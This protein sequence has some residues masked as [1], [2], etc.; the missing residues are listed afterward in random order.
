MCKIIVPLDQV[1]S[2]DLRTLLEIGISGE[3]KIIE[4]DDRWDLLLY[5]DCTIETIIQLLDICPYLTI[6][7]NYDDIVHT[8]VEID[9]ELTTML[10]F[11]AEELL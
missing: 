10:N 1:E 11:D 5:S 7:K 2:T 9:V 3:Q 4:T 8:G 6:R